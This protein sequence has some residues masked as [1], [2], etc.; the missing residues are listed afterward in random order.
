[1]PK[2]RKA[3]GRVM[4]CQHALPTHCLLAAMLCPKDGYLFVW[5]RMLLCN[6]E[7]RVSAALTFLAFLPAWLS[8]GKTE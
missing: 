7:L 8:E 1:M 2:E 6:R 5:A 4:P 3:L